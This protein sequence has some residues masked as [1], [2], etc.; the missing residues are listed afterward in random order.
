MADSMETPI[1]HYLGVIISEDKLQA[2]LQ[3][4]HTDPNFI[5][6]VSQLE[7][8]LKHNMV[9]YGIKLEVLVQFA[10][11]PKDYFYSKVLIANGINPSDGEDGYINYMYELDSIAL[12]PAEL[13]DGTVDYKEVI[14]LNNIRK[15]QLIAERVMVKEGIIGKAVTGEVLIPRKGMDVRFKMGKNVI[16]DAEQKSLYAAIDGII[17]KTDRDKINVFP[18]YEVKGDVDYNIGNI[19]FVGSVVIRGNVL[20]GFRVKAA[21]DIRVT[22]GVE[23]ADLEA[24][25]SIDISVGILGHNRGLIKAGINIRTSFV[26]DANIEAGEE[27]HVTQSIMHSHIKAGKNVICK[28]SKGL[29]VGGV[30]QAGEKVRARTIGNTMSTT[31]VVEVGVLPELRNELLQLRAR[32]K[33]GA[34]SLEKTNKALY[35]LDQ[36]ASAGKL[37]EEKLELRTR[38]NHTKKQSIDEQL[39]MKE[40]ILE[41]EKSLE[42]T[43]KAKV[44]V[45]SVVYGGTKI[46]I[47]R[48]TRFVKDPLSHVTFRMLDGDIAMTSGT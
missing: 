32:V 47:G 44:E 2:Y 22:G 42:D 20:T 34:G 17:A 37:N 5:C 16:T 6:T 4:N 36:L 19:D 30:I 15:G 7:R 13:E 3:F 28:G 25:G 27:V 29:I 39:E 8:L 45:I 14:V 11:N 31:T 43:D 12:K 48:Y 24:A 18:I 33:D 1:E 21:G 23:G 10:A 41:I 40:R 38:L 9:E 35:L 46:V 26:Q